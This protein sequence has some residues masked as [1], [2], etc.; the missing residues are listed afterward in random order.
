MRCPPAA[1]INPI[2]GSLLFGAAIR[3]RGP[4]VED[5]RG[6]R[7]RDGDFALGEFAL[8]ADV[9]S[10]SACKFTEASM[11]LAATNQ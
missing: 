11:M 5:T 9:D 1:R 10:A 4:G 3:V 8:V 2:V 7:F 6:E